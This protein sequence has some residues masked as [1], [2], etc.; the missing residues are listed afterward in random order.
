MKVLLVSGIFFPD[1]GGP[2]THVR[3]IAEHFSSIGWKVTV[4]AFGDYSEVEKGYRVIRVSRRMPRIVSWKMYAL[5]IFIQALRHN[6]L[7]AFDLT[8]GG[9]PAA[10]ASLIFRKPLLLRI[11]G[12]P[13]WERV[14]ERGERHLS[15]VEYY[16]H[17]FYRTDRP[18]LFWAQRFVVG[19]ASRIVTYTDMIKDVYVAHYGA[20]SRL[21]TSIKNPFGVVREHVTR[22]VGTFTFLFAGRFVL[23]KNLIRVIRAFA[24]VQGRHPTARLMFAGE[25]PEERVLRKEANALHVPLTIIPKVDKEHLYTLIRQSSVSLAPAL[26][27]FNPN[28]IMETLALGKPALISRGNGLSV[29]LPNY[30]Q[31][32]SE[33]DNDLESALLRMLE[34]DTYEQ[35][36]AYVASLGVEYRWEDVLA[37]HESLVRQVLK[38]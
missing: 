34:H 24:R 37:A 6:V 1:V 2:A 32:D 19:R 22:E 18:F 9:L 21:M 27:E 35:A 28:F 30:M 12:D 7:Y 23:Y 5:T 4:V 3:N 33:S 17:N 20:D 26:T 8:S 10:L 36:L 29:R 13:I 15:F 16:R 38:A 31:F 14:V 25:G 11:G